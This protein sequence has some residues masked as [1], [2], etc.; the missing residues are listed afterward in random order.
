MPTPVDNTAIQLALRARVMTLGALPALRSWENVEF[1]PTNGQPYIEEDFV[2]ATVTLKGLIPGGL[3][4]NTGLYI[5]KWY[6]LSN[7]GL[8]SITHGVDQLLALFPP[9]ATITASSGDVVRI[10][11][12]VAPYRG[13]LRQ[14]L[15]GWAVVLVTIPYRVLSISVAA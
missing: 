9:G 5:I 10:R 6:G 2:P 7:T 13:Q 15:P 12:D 11:G 14:D 8:N 3:V 1:T 4:E